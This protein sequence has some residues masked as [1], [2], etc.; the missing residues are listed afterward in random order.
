MV[1]LLPIPDLPWDSL[2]AAADEN[3]SW[4]AVV[5]LMFLEPWFQQTHYEAIAFL[6]PGSAHL[7]Q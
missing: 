7:V 1:Y 5:L 4:D 2:A 6:S 3:N